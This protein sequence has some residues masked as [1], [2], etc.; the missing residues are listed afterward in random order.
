M[1]ASIYLFTGPE[2]GEKDEKIESIKSELKKRLGD[3]E[4]LRR[5]ASETKVEEVVGLLQSGSLFSTATCIILREAELIKKKDEL[6]ILGGWLSSSSDSGN[7]LILV[8]DE[9]SVDSKLDRL[10]PASNKKIFWGLDE[11][12]KEEWIR[13]FLRKGAFG[14]SLGIEDDAVSLILDMVENDTASLRSECSRFFFAYPSGH[15][16]TVSDVEKNLAHNREENAFTLFNSM[17]EF[18]ITQ[19]KRLENALSIVQKISLTK[20]SSP[21]A[22]IAGLSSCFRKLEVWHTIHSGGSYPDDF[23]LKTH[24]FKGKTMR[25]QYER[26][27]KIWTLGQAASVV[28]LLS[29]SDIE[30][31][32]MGS[33]VQG[34]ELFILIYEIVMKGG[35]RFAKYDFGES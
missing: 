3:V 35:G 18:G 20:N 8:S 14:V 24:G 16:V 1:A 21:V 22:L 9:I 15:V 31:R 19:Q 6:E 7:V 4:F 10:V 2:F 23:A 29:E 25:Q 12:R 26:A 27:A 32:S 33:A 17:T 28:A 13:S 11:G 5:Y 30:M 34:V